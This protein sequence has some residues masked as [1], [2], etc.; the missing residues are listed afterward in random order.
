MLQS[1]QLESMLV[2]M[3]INSKSLVRNVAADTKTARDWKVNTPE[4]DSQK[5]SSE[6]RFG[7]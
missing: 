4:D 7:K 3:H 2:W 6:N 1:T 5:A